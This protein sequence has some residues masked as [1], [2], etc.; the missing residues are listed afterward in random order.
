MGLMG[1]TVKGFDAWQGGRKSLH[2]WGVQH[3]GET[4]TGLLQ[5]WALGAHGDSGEGSNG[6]GGVT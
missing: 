6:L 2:H 5:A 1:R 3:V 4:V